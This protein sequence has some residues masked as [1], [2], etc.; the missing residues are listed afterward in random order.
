MGILLSHRGRHGK[1]LSFY[2]SQFF[3]RHI[4]E[5]K[6]DDLLL[7]SMIAP[8]IAL[9]IRKD[10]IETRLLTIDGFVQREISTQDNIL[11]VN[12]MVIKKWDLYN[13]F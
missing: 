12:P 1:L 8:E 4:I 10:G 9:L 5:D 11:Q 7:F 2:P 6:V 13:F 3:R